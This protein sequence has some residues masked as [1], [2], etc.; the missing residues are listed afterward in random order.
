[1]LARTFSYKVKVY[2]RLPP[3]PSPQDESVWNDVAKF[4]LIGL[5]ERGQAALTEFGVWED[6]EAC[7]TAVPGR[8]DWAPDAGP[9]E[10]VERIFTDRPVQ[11]QVLPR[12][13]L[14]GALH[15]HILKN[16]PDRIELEY[17]KEVIPI[18]F[19]NDGSSS[20][21]IG[22]T[23]CDTNILRDTPSNVAQDVSEELCDADSLELLTAK[24]LIAA[25]GT[26]RTIA[27]GMEKADKEKRAAMSFMERVRYGP[28]FH[29][30]RYVDDNQRIYKT[31]PMKVPSKWRADLNYSARSKD[32]R[33]LFD[34]LPADAH[35]NQCGAL[36]LKRQ[37]ELAQE[38]S[39]PKKLREAF[40]EVLPQF[41]ALLS[42]EVIET[43]AKKPPSFLPSFRYAAPR[44]NQGDR[45]VVL[46]DAIHTV[47]PYFGLGANSALEDVQILKRS[48]ESTDTMKEATEL[49]S[50]QRADE[51]KALVQISRELDRPGV[52]GVFTFILP[53]V[54]DSI[55]NK[56]EGNRS[57]AD[58][59]GEEGDVAALEK[60]EACDATAEQTAV[61]EE[62]DI[63]GWGFS[64]PRLRPF[65]IISIT[66]LLFTVTDGAI[67]MIVLLHAY[68][69]SFSA[70]EVAVMF[71]LYELAGVFTNL[72]AGMMG[73]RWGIRLTLIM[74]LCL[75]ILSYGLLFGWQ[76]D[77]S[78]SQAIVYVT[79]AQMFA[80]IAKDL[81][82]LGGKT[83]TKLNSLKG[84]GYF[85]G[86]ALLEVSYELALGFMIGLIVI[87]M[88]FAVFGLS[89]D[90]GTAKKKNSSLKEIFVFDNY[91]L[92][93]LSLARLFLFASRDFWFE[94]P[95]PFYL[96]SPNCN[97]L[98]PEYTCSPED[99]S[100]TRGAVC[101]PS[102]DFCTNVN[103]GGGLR[104]ARPR[105]GC[106]RRIPWRIHHPVRSGSELDAATGHR[107]AEPDP[108]QQSS[109]KCSGGSSTATPP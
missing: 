104:R 82:K 1:M 33:I 19:D 74:G 53:L 97:E 25:D 64:D 76:D 50:Q 99:D 14:V 46:G 17:G 72:A 95:L 43:V 51:S 24:L 20:V 49:F 86:S 6:V 56:E 40:D 52:L 29:I 47:K 90:L 105:S 77:W 61:P 12:D 4:Y 87:A 92:N 106:S 107:T 13:K 28:S 27:N 69:K 98:G 32:G 66:Y 59:G 79:I 36:L 85:L 75:Q 39:D 108:T 42:D 35:G 37:D 88:P 96:R 30:K 48:I 68:N 78:K 9:D 101:D 45:T 2:E 15:Q 3:P 63:K 102:V 41:S 10:G 21:L 67:R 93:V 54:V 44:L 89:K 23:D 73:A 100:C 22:V 65:V 18:D 70:L 5:G 58:D 84:V 7:C 62:E 91:N 34:S 8:M 57:M 71:T 11:T 55:F 38:N 94:V 109:L 16:Y 80:G 81:T 31:V 103:T 26:Q 83:V 60:E